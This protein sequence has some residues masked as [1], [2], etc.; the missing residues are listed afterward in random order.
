MNWDAIGTIAE[1]VGA[2]AVVGTLVYLAIQIRQGNENDRVQ[3][4]QQLGRDYAAHTAVVT[5]DGMVGCFMKGLN[6]YGELSPEE[7][8][9]FEYCVG[10]YINLGEAALYHAEVNRLHEAIEMLG[11]YL[12]PRLFAYTGFRDWWRHG[13]GAGF[14]ESTQAWVDDQIARNTETKGFWEYESG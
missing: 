9:K 4:I 14:A 8:A 2:A 1:V 11:A 12:G 3:G 5:N 7:R 10:G 13:D 6:R